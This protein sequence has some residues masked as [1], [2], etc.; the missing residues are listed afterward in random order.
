MIANVIGRVI[1]KVVPLPNSVSM[2]VKP[3]RSETFVLTISNPTPRPETSVTSL[4]VV[5]PGRKRRSSVSLLLSMASFSTRPFSTAFFR[6]ISG[7]IPAP[8][9][10]MVMATWL[11]LGKALSRTVPLSFFPALLLISGGSM[12]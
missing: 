8:S 1:V 6:T 4:L 3:L 9:S 5:K 2:S 12:P 7:S 11:P 10:S